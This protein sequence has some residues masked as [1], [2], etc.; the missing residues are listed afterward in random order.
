MVM[1]NN[2]AKIRQG[3]SPT[4]KRVKDFQPLQIYWNGYLIDAVIRY[5]KNY[6]NHSNTVVEGLT[7]IIKRRIAKTAITED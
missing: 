5:G 7:H 6:S 4:Y 3:A 1:D 2:S